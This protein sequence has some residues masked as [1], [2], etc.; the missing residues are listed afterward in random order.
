MKV[1]VFYAPFGGGHQAT[2]KILQQIATK[3]KIQDL[4]VK[5][6]DISDNTGFVK[7]WLSHFYQNTATK[8][9]HIWAIFYYLTQFKIVIYLGQKLLGL[10]LLPRVTVDIKADKPDLIITTYFVGWVLQ[11]AC[12]KL[13]LKTKV[14]TIVTDPLDVHPAWI[15]SNNDMFV[16]ESKKVANE[17]KSQG[18]DPDKIRVINPVV[19]PEFSEPLTLAKIS[20]LKQKLGLNDVKTI[21]II[22]G[23][24]GL[25]DGDK[26]LAQLANNCPDYNLIVVCGKN[27][28]FKESCDRIKD[29][30]PHQNILVTGFSDQIFEFMNIADLIVTKAGPG[31]IFEAIS[32]RKPIIVSSYLWKQELGVKN[33][34]VENKIGYYQPK[35]SDLSGTINA[36]LKSTSKLD[37]IQVNYTKLD[38]I[39]GN[40]QLSEIVFTRN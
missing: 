2:A 37:Q 31:I 18:L 32:L 3:S 27:H 21:L 23:G 12:Q 26:I 20:D 10:S 25:K 8:Y 13:N 35:L 1:L 14:I 22:G 9:T 4:Q 28:S 11:K 19:K 5:L 6:V 33:F 39:S 40:D 38:F 17:A 29:L 36:L 16:F 7:K 34:V 15:A 30:H 24:E